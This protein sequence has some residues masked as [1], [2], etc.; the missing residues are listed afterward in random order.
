MLAGLCIHFLSAALRPK[1]FTVGVIINTYAH[2]QTLTLIFIVVFMFLCA[3]CDL[4]A[5]A[6]CGNFRSCKAN[7]WLP[8]EVEEKQEEVEEEKERE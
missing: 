1:T 3:G 2:T 7:Q 6:Y 4:L 8:V 5:V